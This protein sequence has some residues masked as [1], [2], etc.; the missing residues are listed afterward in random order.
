MKIKHIMLAR[1]FTLC[2]ALTLVG[3]VISDVNINQYYGKRNWKECAW[4]N[5]ND[6]KDSGLIK[7]LG[8]TFIF[9]YSKCHF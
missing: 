2:L 6:D 1:T 5:V 7:V 3:L 4:N 9:S 8:K